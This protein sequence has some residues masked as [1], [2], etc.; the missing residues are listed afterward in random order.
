[1]WYAYVHC[2]WGMNI[3]CTSYILY[4]RYE[5][6]M[7]IYI[8]I[9]ARICT[10]PATET[11][12][13]WSGSC[14]L[15]GS[16]ECGQRRCQQPPLLHQCTGGVQ[17][18]PLMCHHCFWLKRCFSMS[19]LVILGPSVPKSKIIPK[20]RFLLAFDLIMWTNSDGKSQNT[21]HN[22]WELH[23]TNR[24]RYRIVC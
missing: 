6:I 17:G 16:L 2:I 8:Y 11:T 7:S 14:H 5:Y 9:Y 22:E 20:S 15:Q 23:I 24:F 3:I 13:F 10:A 21:V 18:S 1:M 4:M 12:T 19:S